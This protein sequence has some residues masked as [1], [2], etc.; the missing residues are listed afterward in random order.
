[1]KQ[2]EEDIFEALSPIHSLVAQ[3]LKNSPAMQETPG[4]IPG[5]G[6]SA[7]EGMTTHSNILG[8]PLWLSW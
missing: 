5:L 1:M 7:G 4:S 6:R 3:L 2:L 8:L